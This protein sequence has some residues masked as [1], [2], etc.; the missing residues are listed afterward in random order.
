MQ[1]HCD[2]DSNPSSSVYW[3][4]N[5]TT[6]YSYPTLTIYS[7]KPENY[8]LY[9][10]IASLKDFPKITS[11]SLVLPPG[12]PLIECESIQY[13]SYGERGTIECMI[14]KEPKADVKYSCKKI[15]IFENK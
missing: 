15:Y 12:P 5:D 1:L 7:M 3:T 2:V 11:S 4:L 6:I 10:C 13:L 8:G 14:E 9:K